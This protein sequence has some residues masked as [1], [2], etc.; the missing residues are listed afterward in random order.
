MADL[1][2]SQYV[3]SDSDIACNSAASDSGRTAK[4]YY[5]DSGKYTKWRTHA[6]LF[7]LLQDD[8]M[9]TLRM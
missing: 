9:L 3:A 4:S 8:K 7:S 5:L 2:D 1:S 6:Q